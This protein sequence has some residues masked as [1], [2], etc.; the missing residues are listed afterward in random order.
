SDT[1]RPRHLVF[2]P[3]VLS[4]S[5]IS[6]FHGC[7]SPHRRGFEQLYVPVMSRS[8]PA[9]ELLHVS[10]RYGSLAVLSNASLTVRPGTI[11]AVLG[12]NGA[13]K[14]TLLHVAYGM[15][16]PDA[17]VVRVAGRELCLTSP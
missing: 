8:I 6:I 1:T 7:S 16:H 14:T 3:W 9:L 11:H 2:A 12:E 10:K 5:A 15:I 17:G 13:G 4:S